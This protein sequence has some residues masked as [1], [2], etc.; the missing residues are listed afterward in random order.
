M[1]RKRFVE[2]SFFPVP[3]L[4][5]IVN[6]DFLNNVAKLLNNS[7]VYNLRWTVPLTKSRKAL[8]IK[9][10]N[11][12]KS[13][14]ILRLQIFSGE[15]YFGSTQRNSILSDPFSLL[16]HDLMLLNQTFNRTT[17]EIGFPMVN[18]G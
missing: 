6:L 3:I 4:W 18:V 14:L 2:W 17:Q 9:S 11:I 10:V 16:L 5:Q 13:A 12:Q 1:K 15:F 7:T 8:N